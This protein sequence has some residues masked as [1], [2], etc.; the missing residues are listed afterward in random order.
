MRAT[1]LLALLLLVA[2]RPDV[3]QREPADESRQARAELETVITNWERWV[4]E[5]KVDSMAS[6]LAEN[7]YTLAPNQPAIVG[8]EAWLAAF[9]PMFAQGQWT[10]DITIESVVAYGPLA[11]QRGS[12]VLT[13]APGPGAPS[14]VKA[15]SDTGKYLWRW[16]K[17][18]G[19]WQLAA[20]AWSS[21]R[22]AQP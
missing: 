19:R 2:C 15:M 8:R 18:D 6:V 5:G 12:Y 9:R 14:G 11:V 21:N 10:Y 1:R 22:P 7:S 3:S 13:F 16:Q 20:A 17:V 4:A